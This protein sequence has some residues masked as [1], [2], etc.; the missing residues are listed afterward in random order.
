[1]GATTR[2]Q[3]PSKPA[4]LRTGQPASGMERNQ[5]RAGLL[6]SWMR[7]QLAV[8][9]VLVCGFEQ[10][11][12]VELEFDEVPLPPLRIEGQPARAHTQG[13]EVVDGKFLVTAR[14][15]D[16]RPKRALLLRTKPAAVA[17]DVWDVTPLDEKGAPTSLDHPGGIQSDGT[18]LWIPLAESRRQGRSLIRAYQLRDLAPGR[19]LQPVVE[20]AVADHIGALA[21]SVEHNSLLG[22]S[23]DTEK[24]YVWNLQGELWRKLTA[25]D[26]ELRELGIQSGSAARAGVAVQDWKFVGN[27]L[28]ASGLWRSPGTTIG[29]TESRLMIFT[30][31]LEA[32]FQRLTVKLPPVESTQLSRE[33][34]AVS[35]GVAHF[36]PEDLGATNRMFRISLTNWP[37]GI[38]R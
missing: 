22:A 6:P 36:L 17:W 16:I 7:L 32:D 14:R 11:Q 13:M 30:N 12:A 34:M 3:E 35:E 25:A 10:P 9:A 33:A 24:I 4:V 27:Q 1:M 23:W 19:S 37:S 31:F 8:L 29:S 5:W 15:D 20:F 21:V 26:L 28:F 38:H 18:R 2:L